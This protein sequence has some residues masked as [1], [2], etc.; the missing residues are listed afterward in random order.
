MIYGLILLLLLALVGCKSKSNNKSPASYD[1]GGGEIGFTD[2]GGIKT[3]DEVTDT[4]VRLSWD[5]HAQVGFYVVYKKEL[6]PQAEEFYQVAGVVSFDQT[7]ALITGLK[8]STSYALKLNAYDQRGRIDDNDVVKTVETTLAP[9]APVAV[10]LKEPATSPGFSRNPVFTVRY[11]KPGETVRLF[12]D[13]SCTQEIGSAV[14]AAGQTTIDITTMTLINGGL[15]EVHA[16]ATSIYGYTS[17][18]STAYASYV[19]ESCPDE[20]FVPVEGNEELGVDAFCVFRTEARNDGNDIA[21]STYTGEPWG[22][23]NPNNAKTACRNIS[24]DEGVCDLISNVEWLAIARN[25][26]ATAANWS[27]GAVGDGALNTGHSDKDPY[28]NLTISNPNNPWDQTGQ[29]SSTWSQKRT[30]VLSNGGVLW[31][32]AGNLAEWTD[33]EL[34]GNTMTAG[35]SGCSASWTNIY[36]FECEGLNHQDYYPGNPAGIALEDYTADLVGLGK[37]YGGTGGYALRGGK[38]N[39]SSNVPG[40]YCLTLNQSNGHWADAGFRCVWRPQ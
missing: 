39:S 20:S 14:V 36:D 38:W 16:N 8:I 34:G 35:P 17:A 22:M 19:A 2:F 30:H 9:R 1:G 10:S 23:I 15:Y 27:G 33:W 18:C 3:I 31:D 29:D 13:A 11:V 40:I 5:Y 32:F 24:V 26:E 12:K 37:V 21:V 4:T 25:I 28:E 6:A 7:S